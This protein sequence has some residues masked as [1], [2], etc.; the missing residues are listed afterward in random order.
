MNFSITLSNSEEVICSVGNSEFYRGHLHLEIE[1][2]FFEVFY[3][4]ANEKDLPFSS[5][6]KLT[7]FLITL[8]SH[9]RIS[10]KIGTC[11]TVQ[12]Q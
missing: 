8:S 6:S 2:D 10:V 7:A 3:F 4:I 1:H 5:I 12:F 11:C 9:S